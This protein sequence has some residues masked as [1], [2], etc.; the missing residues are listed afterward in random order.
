MTLEV[1]GKVPGTVTETAL[2]LRDD[3]SRDEWINVGRSLGRVAQGVQWI[4]GDWLNYG[5]DH[6][7][8]QRDKYDL[9]SELVGMSKEAL[10]VCAWVAR[11]IEPKDRRPELTF[12]HHKQIASLKPSI[13]RSALLQVAAETQMSSRDLYALSNTIVAPTV[14]DEVASPNLGGQLEI[15]RRS[16]PPVQTG[17]LIELGPHRLVVGDSTEPEVWAKL[18]MDQPIASVMWTDPPYGVEYVGKSE[19][20]GSEAMIIDSDRV[21]DL[22]R[23]LALAFSNADRYLLDGSAAYI[24]S[25]YYN[26]D[27]FL[28]VIRALGWRHSTQLVWIKQRMTLGWG[29]YKPQ[30]E[31]QMYVLKGN[32][33]R[34]YGPA[35]RTTVFGL[36]ATSDGTFGYTI[37]NP[38]ASRRHPTM[39]PPKLIFEQLRNSAL[40]GEVVVD[41]FAGSGSTMVAAQQLGLRAFMI[42]Y[43]EQYAAEIVDR[44]EH[45][46]EE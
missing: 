2:I 7:Y 18:F 25:G 17:S 32:N 16:L 30:H 9:A 21:E 34:W 24:C 27:I 41:P 14:E 3:L 43:S 23:L 13:E 31:S 8:I 12:T 15:Q 36:G 26:T 4:L 44:W 1:F 22:P 33:H 20:E 11:S 39:K 45:I 19:A 6:G 38:A 5:V 10:Y 40:N 46:G 42:E 37:P 29:D 35:N 28:D